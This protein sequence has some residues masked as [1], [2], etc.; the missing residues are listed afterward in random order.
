MGSPLPRRR[1][2]RS[3]WAAVLLPALVGLTVLGSC[4]PTRPQ[5]APGR[6]STTTIAHPSAAGQL[7]PF[8]S[9]AR[10]LDGRLRAAAALV[11]GSIHSTGASFDASTV[12][13]V[14]RADPQPVAAAIPSG[15]PPALLQPVLLVYAGLSSRRAAFNWITE[16]TRPAADPDYPRMMQCLRNGAGPASAFERDMAALQRV[17]AATEPFL[18]AAPDSRSAEE[19][20]VRIEWIQLGNNGCGSCG[21]FVPDAWATVTWAPSPTQ[22]TSAFGPVAGNING[23]NFTATYRAD[24]RWEIVLQAC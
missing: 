24:S 21:G 20:A 4:S 8:V 15:A 5:A 9:A 23:L 11:N 14:H 16:G 2:G 17:A 19:L 13:A 22:D 18:P 7:A 6:T 12:Q 10:A 1:G 3:G